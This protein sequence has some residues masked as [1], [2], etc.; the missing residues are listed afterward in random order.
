VCT[1]AALL[2]SLN[3]EVP[4]S[5]QMFTAPAADIVDNNCSVCHYLDDIMDRLTLSAEVQ[6]SKEEL[7]V[8]EVACATRPVF[9]YLLLGADDVRKR[10][11]SL[12]K[13][14]GTSAQYARAGSGR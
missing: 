10:A 14:Y 1:N 6:V 11:A 13:R 8:A 3:L 5:N 12:S 7:S 4:Y 9:K 2:K